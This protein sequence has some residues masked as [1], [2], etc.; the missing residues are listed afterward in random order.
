M[1]PFRIAHLSDPHL[2]PPPS[3]TRPR[4]KQA[5]SRFAWRRKR[6]H[7]QPSV[8]AA[9]VADIKAQQPDHVALTGDLV[10]FSTAEE[11]AA[12]RD[13]LESLAAPHDLTVSPG[14]H[15]ALVH[16]GADPWGPWRPWMQDEPGDFPSVRVRGPVAVINLCSAVPTHLHLAQGRL[17]E[18]QIARLDAVLAEAA[19][20]GLYRLI[21]VHHPAAKGVVSGRKALVDL[22]ALGAVLARRGAELVLHGHG[23]EAAV[24]SLEGPAGPIPVLGVPSASSQ[25]GHHAPARWHGFEIARDGG[26]FVTRMTARGVGADGRVDDLGGY[27]LA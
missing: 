16:N 8:L 21:L 6:H 22:E 10:N 7:H 12:A 9:I 4:L 20:R 11:I 26:R 3:R 18:S 27:V 24:S 1:P 14:N 17:G 19:D 5:M 25:G 15:D 13:W 2:P 23:H